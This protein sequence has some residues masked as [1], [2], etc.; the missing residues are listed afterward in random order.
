M[1]KKNKRIYKS[2][3]SDYNENVLDKKTFNISQNHLITY[4]LL[5]LILIIALFNAFAINNINYQLADIN[6]KISG[7]TTTPTPTTQT[8]T[9]TTTTT[10]TTT[11][12]T[13]TLDASVLEGLP[14]IGDPN[15][16]VTIVEFY[17]L[18]CGFCKRHND[19]TAPLLKQNYVDNGKAKIVFADFISVGNSIIH[20]AAYCVREQAGDQAFLDM[21]QDIYANQQSLSQELLVTLATQNGAD[22]AEFNTC[23]ESRKYQ[24]QITNTTAY[25]RS[26]GFS[27]TPGFY[28]E[29][30]SLKG[31]YPYESFV[32]VI[33]SKLN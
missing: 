7:T 16:P 20:E 27:G 6:S 1:S 23:L 12:P 2:N 5:I 29:G 31:A 33:E 22:E 17:D 14:I 13:T 21:K 25:G 15:A 26:L 18:A 9:T 11:T 10:P 3:E 28:I 32:E 4:A 8:T 30:E 19:E 24:E